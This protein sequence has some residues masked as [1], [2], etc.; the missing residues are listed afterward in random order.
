M[1]STTRASPGRGGASALR[2]H[3]PRPTRRPHPPRLFLGGPASHLRLVRVAL[4]P[5]RREGRGRGG[6]ASGGAVG[7]RRPFPG[8]PRG[9][10][11]YGAGRPSGAGPARSLPPASRAPAP[12]RALRRLDAQ[13]R[14]RRRGAP[15]RDSLGGRQ[16]RPGNGARS[17]DLRQDASPHRRALHRRRARRDRRGDPPSPG[18]AGSGVGP[19]PDRRLAQRDLLGERRPLSG[20]GAA[21]RGGQQPRDGAARRGGSGPAGGRGSRRGDARR[22]GRRFRRVIGEPSGSGR[23][24]TPSSSAMSRPSRPG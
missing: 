18:G 15:G 16:P 14:A 6:Q 11:T 7:G 1:G 10:R 13:V 17:K 2:R 9:G 8:P 24:S 23:P 3:R 21:P 20:E 22:R 4:P 12:E 19:A 5:R